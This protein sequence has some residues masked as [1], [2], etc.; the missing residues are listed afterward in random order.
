MERPNKLVKILKIVFSICN[1]FCAGILL[2]LVM[3]VITLFSA[4]L[5]TSKT[6]LN[7]GF[8]SAIFM[9]FMMVILDKSRKI[10]KLLQG[11]R[12]NYRWFVIPIIALSFWIIGLIIYLSAMDLSNLSE[13][14]FSSSANLNFLV[15]AAS[16]LIGIIAG[17][18][19]YFG[20]KNLNPRAIFQ[21]R[22]FQVFAA[23][24]LLFT[25]VTSSGIILL[26]TKVLIFPTP[27]ILDGNGYN[28]GPWLT[29]QEDPTTSITISWLTAEKNKTVV[30]YGTE[31]NNLD[32]TYSVNE[33]VNL[34]HAQLM[35]LSPDTQY[36]YRIPEEFVQ[37]HI[38]TL[39]NFTTAPALTSPRSFKFAV[40]GDVQPTDDAYVLQNKKVADGLINGS[41]DFILNT[42]DLAT[43]GTNLNAWHLLMMNYARI[44]ANTPIQG[45]IGNHDWNGAGGSSNYGALF[46]YP[47]ENPRAGRFYS[48]D[49]LNAHFVM[50]DNFERFYV[51]GSE[52]IQ[53]IQQDIINARNNNPD[54]WVFCFFHLSIMTT[55]TTGHYYDLQKQL[56]PIFD[57][58]AVDAVF[59][60]HDHHYEHYN[61][62]YGVTGAGLL[63]DKN[64]NWNHNEVQY[65]CTGGGGADL[66]VNYQVLNPARMVSTRT[67]RQYNPGTST[68]EDNSYQRRAWNSVNYIQYLDFGI[69]YT[70]G[71][72]HDGKYYYHDPSIESYDDYSITVGFDY[73]EQCF[74]FMQ[75]EINA[76]GDECTISAHYPNGVLLTG[77]GGSKPQIWTLRK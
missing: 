34:H 76:A 23:F 21:K 30:Y 4:E 65:F 11:K 14:D 29:W 49:Y 40:F 54:C 74:E 36:F 12:V 58:L 38:S 19:I 44:G 55:A 59:Y 24:S 31:E 71:N 51:M 13:F 61:Y 6:A 69:N 16:S 17:N 35:G 18:L 48:F 25:I 20:L 33:N 8:G 63:W 46:P 27:S 77:P 53:W 28:D 22:K 70:A 10:E 62:T 66:E 52:Q 45:T 39:F 5:A 1:F 67:V 75:V 60:G 68:Y 42:G 9:F 73:G 3:F 50:I 2:G 56:V 47:Y 57:K 37:D 32:Q 43:D 72:E 64:H 26:Y 41:F 15:Y 7:L